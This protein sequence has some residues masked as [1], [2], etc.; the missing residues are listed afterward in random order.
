MKKTVKTIVSYLLCALMPLSLISCAEAPAAVT[1]GQSE[2]QPTEKLTQPATETEKITEQP[3]TEAQTEP[4][5]PPAPETVE[6]YQLAPEANSLMMSY[7]IITPNK[8]V[9]VFDGGI[10]GNG[11]D[12]KPY[13]QNAIRAILEI[14]END[15]FEVEAWFLTHAHRDHF[16]EL[17]KMMNAYTAESNYRIN[18]FYFDFPEI[19]VEWDSAAGAGDT[20]LG[21]LDKLKASFDNYYSVAGFNG[22]KGADI[23]EDKYVKPDG[24]ENYYY[25]LINGAVVNAENIEKGLTIT[26][27]G[28]DFKVYMTWWKEARYV[29]ST[30]I[31]TKM[32]FGDHSVLFLGDAASDSGKRLLQMY[33][34]EELK[35]EY[36]QMGHHGQGGPDKDFYDAIDAKNSIRLWPTPVWVWTN[37][38]TYKIGETR[39]WLDLPED[40]T[41]FKKEGYLKTGKDL[42]AGV[43]N[44]FPNQGDKFDKWKKAIISSQ[45]VAVFEK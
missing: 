1:D 35:S 30:S 43:T 12:A 31:I 20:D 4:P 33:S 16:Y 18:N 3:V 14:G 37:H 2:A 28:V 25:N 21:Y 10:D 26:V 45:R 15:Y 23:P 19:G 34:G 8:K 40:A 7:V 22:I 38:K 11:L 27:D 13:L 32:I 24:A 29:N 41:V 17:C 39:K 9:V 42:I 44:R 36:V 5:A 6:L